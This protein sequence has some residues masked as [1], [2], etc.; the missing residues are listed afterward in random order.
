MRLLRVSYNHF[1]NLTVP[2][3]RLAGLWLARAGFPIGTR[4]AV[5][6]SPSRIVLEPL[7]PSSS[8]A[9][10]STEPTAQR[11]RNP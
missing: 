11:R 4:I 5:T 2:Y 6:V 9:D 3:V 8:P 1:G 10:T 7:E